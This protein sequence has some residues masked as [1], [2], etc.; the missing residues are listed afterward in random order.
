MK[1]RGVDWL[2]CCAVVRIFTCMAW[3]GIRLNFQVQRHN[4]TPLF[5][6]FHKRQH[7]I[8]RTHINKLQRLWPHNDFSCTSYAFIARNDKIKIIKTI[9]TMYISVWNQFVNTIVIIFYW[10]T[11]Y[12][13]FLSLFDDIPDLSSCYISIF[14]CGCDSLVASLYIFHFFCLTSGDTTYFHRCCYINI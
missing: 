2:V 3:H 8:Y 14:L 9:I 4:D 10:V 6:G 13:F 5:M 11:Y 12:L 1:W 7:D